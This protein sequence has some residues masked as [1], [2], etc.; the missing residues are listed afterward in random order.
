VLASLVLILSIFANW[1]Q[2]AVLD[3]NQIRNTTSQILADPHVQV[4][5]AT[6]AVDQLYA[7]VDVQGQIAKELPSA[8]APL[9]VPVA[10]ATRNLAI[11]VAEKALATPQ[12][13]AL[14]SG[15]IAR[16][17]EQFVSLIRDKSAFVSTTGGVVTLQYGAIIADLAARLGI[18]P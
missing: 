13:Q 6:Y 17:Q 7:N 18:S 5:L 9:A 16:A 14:V 15:A 4:A 3:T 11:N 12:V 8:A 10:A 1:V 2:R